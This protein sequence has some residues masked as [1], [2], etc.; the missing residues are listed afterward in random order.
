M[1]QSEAEELDV[2]IKMLEAD[3]SRFKN[4]ISYAASFVSAYQVI[5]Q[6]RQGVEIVKQ[7]DA[8]MTEMRK[9]TSGTQSQLEAYVN[10]TGKVAD[11]I[12]TNAVTLQNSAAD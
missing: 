5:G 7:Y 1:T 8:A 12:G 6:I 3:G 4:L 9:V 10:T 11:A 2:R